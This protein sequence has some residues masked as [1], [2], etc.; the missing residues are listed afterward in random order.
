MPFQPGLKLLV[1][2][3]E[4]PGFWHERLILY[5]A[6]LH[7]HAVMTGD[8]DE[9]VE[10]EDWWLTVT[11]MTGRHEYPPEM[12]GQVVQFT[13]PVEGDELM[14]AIRR[15]RE[16]ALR[17]RAAHPDLGV[18]PSPTHAWSWTGQRLAIPD[19]GIG[20]RFL[21]MRRKRGN[22]VDPRFG[23]HQ[24]ML[25]RFCPWTRG[26]GLRLRRGRLGPVPHLASMTE[27]PSIW[28]SSST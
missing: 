21:R 17:E 8:G 2:F 24:P 20:D 12:T 19:R 26:W 28:E 11:V 25:H 22:A 18:P 9:Y 5:P 10:H 4:D 1:T 3:R 7:S 13:S 23:R 6:T 27:S 15:G 14:M 16:L